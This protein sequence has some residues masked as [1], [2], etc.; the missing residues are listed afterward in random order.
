M[1]V[2]KI[3]RQ[4]GL[5]RDAAC[6]RV[7]AIAQKLQRELDAEYHWEGDT[8]KFSR[9][10]ASGHIVVSESDLRVEIKLGMLLSALKGKITQSLNEHLDSELNA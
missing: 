1:S 6:E 8:L 7:E 5:G 9:S 4:H 2:I 10:G 3:E